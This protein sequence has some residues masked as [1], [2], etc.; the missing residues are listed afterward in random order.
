MAE[1]LKCPH[2]GSENVTRMDGKGATKKFGKDVMVDIAPDIILCN[3]CKKQFRD[4]FFDELT[5]DEATL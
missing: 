5:V 4:W 1:K 3:S 2:C